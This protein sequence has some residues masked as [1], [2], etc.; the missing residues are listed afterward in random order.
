MVS[1]ITVLKRKE[2]V[3][4]PEKI[5]KR[6]LTPSKIELVLEST[7]STCARISAKISYEEK[8]RNGLQHRKATA[9]LPISE[10]STVQ[11]IENLYKEQ[12]RKLE[13]GKYKIFVYDGGGMDIE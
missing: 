6:S 5:H 8:S 4:D 9:V 2:I 1:G 7:E 3:A 13:E 10:G 11:D 12:S